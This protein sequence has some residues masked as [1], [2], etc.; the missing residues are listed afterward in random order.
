MLFTRVL[1]VGGIDEYLGAGGSVAECAGAG[2]A[3]GRRGVAL[4]QL[5]RIVNQAGHVRRA[6][7]LQMLRKLQRQLRPKKTPQRR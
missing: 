7:R 6:L 5:Q 2:R 3:G 4:A 1:A